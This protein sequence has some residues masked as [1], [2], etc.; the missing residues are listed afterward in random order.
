MEQSASATMPNEHVLWANNMLEM[1]N[2]VL[3]QSCADFRQ[4]NDR[5]RAEVDRLERMN[6]ILKSTIEN[7]TRGNG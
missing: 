5:L 6:K 1:Q 7:M 2:E 4:E 3:R